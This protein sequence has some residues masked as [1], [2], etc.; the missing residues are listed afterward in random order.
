MPS[1]EEKSFPGEDRAP[2]EVRSEG[3]FSVASPGSRACLSTE[4][5]SVGSPQWMQ[6]EEEGWFG[7]AQ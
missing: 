4:A 2:G 6:N 5:L 3:V 1:A 7:F